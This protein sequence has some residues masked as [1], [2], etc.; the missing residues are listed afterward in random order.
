MV[1]RSLLKAAELEFSR[2]MMAH[3]QYIRFGTPLLIS[4]YQNDSAAL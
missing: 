3:G 4:I 1:F 2:I